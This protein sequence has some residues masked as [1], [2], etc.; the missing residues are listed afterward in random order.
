MQQNITVKSKAITSTYSSIERRYWRIKMLTLETSQTSNL[1]GALD[2]FVTLTQNPT[3]FTAIYD[4]DAV[5]R[6]TP[7]ATI[8]IEYL[9]TQPGMVEIMRD[10]Y[11]SPT[12]DLNVLLTY[13]TDSLGYIFASHLQSHGFDPAFYRQITVEND[14]T[15]ITLRRSQTHDIHHLITGFGTDLPN[16]LGLQAFELAQM[17]SPLA[18]ALLSSGIVHSLSNP[19][20]L[21]HTVQLIQQG[22]QMG[23]K[24]K[25]LTAER[26]ED[27]WEKS[28]FELRIKL[29][30]EAIL[31]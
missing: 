2:A 29:G 27:H 17:R 28:I 20:A 10:R 21:E 31:S 24:A 11:L 25:P 18:I 30:V 16:E 23:L 8:S 4:I 3:D 1:F 7:L 22:W 14:I 6:Q 5:L 13:P 9:K 15:Y 12:P 26:W 19:S